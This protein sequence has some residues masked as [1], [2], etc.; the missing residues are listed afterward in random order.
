MAA[1]K[2]WWFL[3]P[4][5]LLLVA[6]LAMARPG[7][8]SSYG[9]GGGSSSG[10][11]GSGGDGL[12]AII[13]LIIEYP[14]IG[15][16]LLIIVIAYRV[17]KSRNNPKG[18][19]SSTRS[20]TSRV[21]QVQHINER[22]R[23]YQQVDPQF[24]TTIFLDFAQ[25]LFYQFHHWRG[26]EDFRQLTPFIIPDLLREEM[27]TAGDATEVSEL[28][29]GNLSA[30]NIQMGGDLETITVVFE[31]NYT[32]TRRGHSNRLF[33]K[34]QWIFGRAPGVKSKGPEELSGLHCP[35]CGSHL[36]VSPTGACLQCGQVVAPGVQHWTLIN[37]RH[38]HREVSRGEAIGNYTAEQG[39]QSPNVMDPQLQ[40]MGNQFVS[41][42]NIPDIGRYFA[43]MRESVINPIFR[44]I[45]ASWEEQ[46]YQ[47][48][49]PLMTDNLFRSHR[50]WLE[51]YQKAGVVNR[52][53]NL[54]IKGSDVV[55]IEMDQ[56]YESVT[57]RIKASVLDYLERKSSGKLVAG[58]KSS[59]RYFTEYWTFVR[60]SGVE[61]P[62]QEYQPDQCPNCG[63][64]VDMGMTG[65]CSYCNS[66]VTS[67]EFSWVLSR[68]TQ[69]E[70][71]LG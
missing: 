39:S 19:V 49:R 14:Q 56:F 51:T 64:P 42:H 34:D 52:L 66:K 13:Y 22:L 55:K 35:N 11:G 2:K 17:Y 68:I 53:Q 8:G 43:S 9:G 69:D 6:D 18:T 15:I 48:A 10:G 59:A 7:G 65:V 60:R 16:P 31:A 44:T 21:K 29:I 50:Y 71:Y 57:V 26:K 30:T 62:D 5:L 27:K 41:T 40:A 20:S 28:V 3:V 25:H 4:M 1:L 70:A 61:K 37:R 45:Y 63:A 23:N 46:D 67:G 58:S 47:K 12:G 38:L 36:E 33:V 32:E 24:S 54:Q